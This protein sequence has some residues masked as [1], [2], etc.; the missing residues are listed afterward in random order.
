MVIIDIAVQI[1]IGITIAILS[2]VIT[3]FQQKWERDAKH[4]KKESELIKQSIMV[5]LG[6][7]LDDMYT[8]Y[9]DVGFIPIEKLHQARLM[10]DCYHSLGGNGTGTAKMNELDRLPNF[11]EGIK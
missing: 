8:Y 6:K 5:L 2:A 9:V 3:N 1:F 11:P 10:Y 7:R 4:T